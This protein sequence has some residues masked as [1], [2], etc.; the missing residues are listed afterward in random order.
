[1]MHRQVLTGA[2]QGSFMPCGLV[3]AVF[4]QAVER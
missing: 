1:L 4:L 2:S 3:F